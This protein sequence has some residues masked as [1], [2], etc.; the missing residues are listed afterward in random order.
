MN[1]FRQ[2]ASTVTGVIDRQALESEIRKRQEDADLLFEPERIARLHAHL[3][4][5][6]VGDGDEGIPFDF[7]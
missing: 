7:L 6:V 4:K 5:N 3:S 2:S 1:A